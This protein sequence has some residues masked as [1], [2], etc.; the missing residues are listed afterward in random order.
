MNFVL[1]NGLYHT[2][3]KIN[4]LTH[5]KPSFVYGTKEGF[6]VIR[7]GASDHNSAGDFLAGV[8]GGLGGEIVGGFVDDDGFADDLIHPEAAGEDGHFGFSPAGQ[9]GR[10]ISGMVG[11][12][13]PGGVE[14]STTLG[15]VPSPTASPFVDMKG[16]KP[17]PGKA[18]NLSR[19]QHTA[20]VLAEANG[21]HEFWIGSSAADTGHRT[22]QSTW[23]HKITSGQYMHQPA[24]KSPTN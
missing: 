1:S 8:A 5:S 24:K 15:E 22:G 21:S 12:G 2:S 17:I 4:L 16:I 11:V 23:L 19:H 18:P 6:I 7:L 20:A 14:V 3:E 13:L 10:Q 9:Q